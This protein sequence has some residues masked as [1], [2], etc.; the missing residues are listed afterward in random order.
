MEIDRTDILPSV[1]YFLF[2]SVKYQLYT[3]FYF[4]IGSFE[5]IMS[6]GY[7]SIIREKPII[8]GVPFGKVSWIKNIIS[9]HCFASLLRR[10]QTHQILNIDNF[11][12]LS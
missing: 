12:C 2:I 8:S 6:R 11:A 10:V 7:S 9:I 1:Y 5:G 3:F 4:F